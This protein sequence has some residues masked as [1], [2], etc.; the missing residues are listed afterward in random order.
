MGHI[1]VDL[2]RSFST[3]RRDFNSTYKFTGIY[4]P[5][6][7]GHYN[8]EIDDFSLS[9]LNANQGLIA[10]H[11]FPSLLV[12]QSRHT[13][14][15]EVVLRAKTTVF[16]YCLQ[17]LFPAFVHKDP[18]DINQGSGSIAKPACARLYII[19]S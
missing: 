3:R 18:R 9:V 1:D 10:M 6:F 4:C 5:F 19:V 7:C 11:Y 15:V 16:Q 17:S 13:Q 12:Q 2:Y 8:I 14:K